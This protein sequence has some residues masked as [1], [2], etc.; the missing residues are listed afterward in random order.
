[1]L[2]RAKLQLLLVPI[3]RV[4]G[5]VTIFVVVEVFV[6]QPPSLSPSTDESERVGL[7]V[8]FTSWRL[9]FEVIE[10]AQR[11]VDDQPAFI[12]DFQ[13]EVDIFKPVLKSF[14]ESTRR[15]KDLSPDQHTS[16]RNGL[17]CST[18]VDRRMVP[19][20]TL[21]EMVRRQSFP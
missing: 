15:L 19:V 10:Y 3:L 6:C 1:M 18:P 5:R 20:G 7:F 14:I 4:D 17:E 2:K 12:P 16:G 21:I 8:I 9:T 13:T 11:L